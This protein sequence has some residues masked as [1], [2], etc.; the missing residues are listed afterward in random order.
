MNVFRNIFVAL[1]IVS[2][3]QTLVYYPQVPDIVASHFDGAGRPNGWMSKT[4]FF[5]IH[6]A[7]MLIMALSFLYLPQ[8]LGR[9]SIRWWNLPNKDHW[10]SPERRE[11]TL[12]FIR[13]QMLLF[14]SATAALLIVTIQL[15]IEA[16]LSPPPVLSSVIGGLLIGY[17]AFTMVWLVWFYGRFARARK[18]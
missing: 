3:I 11:E 8:G 16:N 5:G 1:L 17:F 14:G 18:A 12:L 15:A 13:T 7:M 2:V 9:F 10:L 6:L 4:A